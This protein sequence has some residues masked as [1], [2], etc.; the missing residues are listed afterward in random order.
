[1]QKKLAY[2]FFFLIVN[3]VYASSA[4]I[5]AVK[6]SSPDKSIV[7]SLSLNAGQP[8]YLIS[9]NGKMVI[10]SSAIG[11]IIDK[12]QYVN[13]N[14]LKVLGR[15][16]VNNTYS[17]RGVHSIAIN[18]YNEINVS[19][20]G[21][22]GYRMEVRVFNDGVAF[23]Y[24]IPKLEDAIVNQDLSTFQIPVGSI[25]WSQ[26]DINYY[27]G[28]YHR[29]KIEDVKAGQ[30]A[31][32]PLTIQTPD[33]S[34]YA[35]ITESGLI[36][37]AGMSLSAAGDRIFKANLSGMPHKKGTIATPWRV[38]SIG[39]TL[40][41]LVNSDVIGNLAPPP[42]RQLFP[43]GYNTSWIRPGKSVWSWL[44]ENGGV[45]FENMKKF[46]SWAGELGIEYNLVDE[47]WGKW[48]SPGK[49]KW[50]MMKDLVDYS[51][52][53]GVK[54]WA[55]KAYPD[56][57]G[58]P[59]I[60]DSTARI[61]FFKKCKEVGIAGLKIDFFDSESQEI[62][63]FYQSALKDAAKYHLMLDFHGANKPTGESR[64][65]PNEMTREGIMGL[66]GSTNWA[67]HNTTL[68][69]TRFL[70][71]HADYTPLSFTEN[72]K[73]T[74]LTHQLAC[75]AA[76]T[77][78]FMCLG[79]DPEKLLKSNIKTIVKDIPVVWDETIIL[80]QSEIG[81][82]AVMARR[83]GKVWYL[84]ALNG[85]SPKSLELNLDFLSSRKYDGIVFHDTENHPKQ[86]IDE[87]MEFN[88]KNKITVKMSSGGGFLARF[89]EK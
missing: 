54:I 28:S 19:V 85:E 45:T 4:Q 70:A 87:S 64:T 78:P 73:G 60:K 13:G 39:T 63:Q 25:I 72:I 32:P 22:N 11:L 52:K 30:V 2:I 57:A 29:Q 14:A 66:E 65:W 61:A 37:F 40:N 62:I 18:S 35:A 23:R 58:I 50:A 80:P 89:I 21:R 67:K 44:A 56:R 17:T 68:I 81:E 53:K 43:K 20:E 49:D 59:G 26:G 86:T 82:L 16:S 10:D 12:Q 84:I 88:R 79:V 5:K 8:K 33:H 55:W 36:D 24:I 76:F 3:T 77:S 7:Y 71:G 46:S 51:N 1:M 69:F 48:E 9:L 47:G 6:I 74:T 31:G 42:N 41:K 38:I 15:K 34:G 27:E 75:V 83:S